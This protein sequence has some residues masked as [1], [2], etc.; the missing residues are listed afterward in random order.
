MNKALLSL[1]TILA[2]S[3]F[4]E[5]AVLL[6]DKAASRVNVDVHATTDSF[7][8][9]LS[10]YEAVIAVDPATGSVAN[11]KLS[12]RVLDIKTGKDKRD[13]AMHDWQKTESFPDASFVMESIQPSVGNIY[14]VKGTFTFHG[15]SKPLSFPLTVTRK[16][17]Q[18]QFDGEAIIDTQ[19]YTLPIIRMMMVIKVDPKV[20]VAFH[21][22]AALKP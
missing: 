3:A 22:E 15:V 17:K 13:R 5:P 20:K 11:C 6:V 19:D 9:Q 8:G 18:F 1:F 2:C 14:S 16:D 21:L 12:F 10:N 4:A 7:I